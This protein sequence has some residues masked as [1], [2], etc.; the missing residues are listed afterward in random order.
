MQTGLPVFRHPS[1]RAGC[2]L[3]LGMPARRSKLWPTD[4]LLSLIVPEPGFAGLE[5]C[6][7]RVSS[8]VKVLRRMLAGRAVTTADVSALG[9]AAQVQPPPIRSKTFDATCPARRRSR[10]SARMIRFHGSHCRCLDFKGYFSHTEGA[11]VNLA[12]LTVPVESD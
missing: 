7:D 10:I 1:G 11:F 8:C 9:A 5:A 3:V 12:T 6:R 4:H 2:G